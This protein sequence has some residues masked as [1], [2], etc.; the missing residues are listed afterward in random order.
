MGWMQGWTFL[1]QR[2]VLVLLHTTHTH[3]HASRPVSR[4]TK[5]ASHLESEDLVKHE[6]CLFLKELEGGKQGS[7]EGR[8]EWSQKVKEEKGGQEGRG[9]RERM[10]A[11]SLEPR[12]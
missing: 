1:L 9:Q 5:Y 3:T 6:P 12:R 10:D 8:E 4:V 11:R 7:K 2:V